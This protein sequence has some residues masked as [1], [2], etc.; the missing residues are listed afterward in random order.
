MPVLTYQLQQQALLPF[1]AQTLNMTRV[2][3]SSVMGA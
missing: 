2:R 3:V 1:L